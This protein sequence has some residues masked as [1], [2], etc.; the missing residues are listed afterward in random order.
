MKNTINC[1]IVEDDE[2]AI[3]ILADYIAEIPQLN[4]I[5][6]FR[7]PIEAL[8]EISAYVGENLVFMDISMPKMSGIQLAQSLSKTDSKIIFTTAHNGHAIEAFNVNAKHYLLKPIELPWFVEVVNNVISKDFLNIQ[9]FRY[10]D[11]SL[12]FRTGERGLL[13]RRVLSQ[14]LFFES[15]NNYVK[16][17]T[18]EETFKV[19][20]TI[21]EIE[22][23][24]KGD[25]RFYRVQQCYIINIT[26]VD[27][28]V[29]NTVYLGMNGITM[30]SS[31][32]R[33]YRTYLKSRT[34]H[35]KR[36]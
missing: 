33:T 27:R 3:R 6:T 22:E 35:S 12:F 5:S 11:E 1:F 10:D 8:G 30:T 28:I 24:L 32:D 16:I 9:A 23:L 4:L 31:F 36:L 15:A 25:T 34:L 26:F 2:F 7:N 20:M 19:Y 21:S 18:A 14:I 13:T 29:G 17:V